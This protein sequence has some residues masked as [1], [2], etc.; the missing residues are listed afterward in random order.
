MMGDTLPAWQDN[1]SLQER[2]QYMLDNEIATD[3]C[4]EIH[5]PEGNVT[6][7]RAHKFM[8]VAG[9]PVF[10]AMLCGGMS[11]ARPDHGNI[12]IQDIDAATFKELLRFHLHSS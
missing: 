2:S 6:L 7:V 11:E 8:L 1:K 5:S 12:Q 4:F 3:V 10:E 9:S